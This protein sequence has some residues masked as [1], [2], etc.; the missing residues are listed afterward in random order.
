M[1]KVSDHIKVIPL[2]G[3][4]YCRRFLRSVLAP[5]DSQPMGAIWDTWY[6]PWQRCP[7]LRSSSSVASL[8][9]STSL[10][11]E[12][13]SDSLYMCLMYTLW[14]K[15][16]HIKFKSVPSSTG[17]LQSSHWYPSFMA[18]IIKFT[19]WSAILFRRM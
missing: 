6:H 5:I 16:A 13:Y 8:P 11:R 12:L 1:V 9:R 7:K 14:R 2:C 10:K 18:W 3:V 4:G 17:Q 19:N 15:Y